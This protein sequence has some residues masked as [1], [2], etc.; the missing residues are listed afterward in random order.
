[1][2][3]HFSDRARGHRR[4]L[5]VGDSD[6]GMEDALL[7][8]RPAGVAL[9]PGNHRDA[10]TAHRGGVRVRRA[11]AGIGRNP[12]LM[13]SIPRAASAWSQAPDP[14]PTAIRYACYAFLALIL[15]LLYTLA[16]RQA[17]HGLAGP[18]LSVGLRR[19]PSRL[20]KRCAALTG[21]QSDHV[22][23]Q[24][25]NNPTP[26][27]FIRVRKPHRFRYDHGVRPRDPYLP[28]DYASA[29]LAK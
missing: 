1:M 9:A 10:R 16:G 25:V 6:R 2:D 20:N 21:S 26:L 11:L 13:T 27:T 29:V 5:G 12:S 3:P 15:A 17:Q 22:K 28:G 4:V 7:R 19:H 18:E 8:L 24:M 14:A 23:H